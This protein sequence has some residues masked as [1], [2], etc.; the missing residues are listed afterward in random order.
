MV[1]RRIVRT[2]PCRVHEIRHPAVGDARAPRASAT[3]WPGP[4]PR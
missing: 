1:A 4:P 3:A 2:G